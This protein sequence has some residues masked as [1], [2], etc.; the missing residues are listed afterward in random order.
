ME[1]EN[2]TSI[3]KII[4][5]RN[6]NCSGWGEF[7][8]I[9]GFIFFISLL[10][11]ATV[12]ILEIFSQK[13]SLEKKEKLKKW[14]KISILFTFFLYLFSLLLRVFYYL[15]EIFGMLSFFLLIISSI[16]IPIAVFWLFLLFKVPQD[17]TFLK[18]LFKNF[19]LF[20]L[21]SLFFLIF[22]WLFQCFPDFFNIP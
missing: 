8:L 20:V 16:V 6:P 15:E 22:L 13:F 18:F 7:Y 4:F 19:S 2:K 17:K 9:G 14:L 11:P 21:F 12:S 3:F 1:K 10:T 5:S